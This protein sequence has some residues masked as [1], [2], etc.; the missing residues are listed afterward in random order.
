MKAALPESSQAIYRRLASGAFWSLVGETGTRA[1]SFIGA[2]LVA[3]WLGAADFGAFALVQGT[4]TTFT[5]FATFG[6]GHTASRYIAAYRASAPERIEGIAS[7]T[8]AFAAL[9]G[10]V[11]AVVLFLAAPWIAQTLLKAPELAGPLRWVTPILVLFAVSGALAGITVGFEAFQPQAR[12]AWASGLVSFILLVGGVA[13][14]GLPGALKG[15]LLSE[16]VRCL[17]QYRLAR[18]LMREHG[19]SLHARPDLREMQVLWEYS[20]PLLLS[21]MLHAPVMWLCQVII[22]RQANGIAQVGMYDAAQKW[23]TL[24]MIVP[25]AASAAFTPV[26]AHM[27]GAND[28]ANSRRT[29]RHLAGVQLVFTVIPAIVVALAAQ[30]AAQL[31]GVSFAA[32]TP[33]IVILMVLAPVFVL[34]HLYWQALMSCGYAWTSLFLSILWAL[35]ALALTWWWQAGGAAALAKALLVAYAVTLATNIGLL[36]WLWSRDLTANVTATDR[37]EGM[38]S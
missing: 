17:L 12:I 11:A 2:V 3:R 6:M 19:R 29:T 15:L 32:A 27:S 1:L 24:V 37:Q 10:L 18:D 28:T 35:L 8:L 14:G 21:A 36:E 30:W 22:A 31:Y 26:M 16:A 7:L 9:M 38:Q 33:V 25:I 34:K 4:I 20:V 5:I 13:L 23:M